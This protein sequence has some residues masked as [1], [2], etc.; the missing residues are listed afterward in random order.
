VETVARRVPFFCH[1]AERGSFAE[2]GF[3]DKAPRDLIVMK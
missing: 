2:A 1:P 3:G